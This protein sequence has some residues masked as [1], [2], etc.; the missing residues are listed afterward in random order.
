MIAGLACYARDM[1]IA[2]PAATIPR[3]A[4]ALRALSAR[5]LRA[6]PQPSSDAAAA[7][8]GPSD[9]DLQ[10]ELA[11]E[12]AT[13]SPRPAAV[14]V[15]IVMRAQLSVLLTLRTDTLPSH[16]GQIS[17]PGGKIDEQDA[18]PAAAA[19]REAWE[20]I[21]LEARLVEPLGYL[22]AYRTGTGYAIHPLVALIEPGFSPRPNPAEVAQVFEVP[23][24]F[25][26]DAANHQRHARTWQGRERHFYA[27]PYGE[28]FIWGATAGIIRNL[29][30]RLL[31]A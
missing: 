3:T 9:F 8:S 2:P 27:M 29:H 15:P 12:L 20:E 31:H 17:F 25:L 23:F 6:A 14:L 21:G 22:D 7:G 1:T 26:M 11:R 16:A 4:A 18:G 24:S 28:H 5:R 30:Q 13:P 19:L 10:P